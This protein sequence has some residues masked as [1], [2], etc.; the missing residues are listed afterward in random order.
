MG[1]S[2]RRLS[3]RFSRDLSSPDPPPLEE[4]LRLARAVLSHR[5]R[6]P[7][8][9]PLSSDY[10]L[11][12]LEWQRRMCPF[13]ASHMN[14]RL[15]RARTTVLM[16]YGPESRE[17]LTFADRSY[18]LACLEGRSSGGARRGGKFFSVFLVEW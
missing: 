7:P 17:F 4:V 11:Y 10:A 14:E 18:A 15:T 1:L 3:C 5:R 12:V 2:V 16:T 6:P 9:P 8:L 13:F